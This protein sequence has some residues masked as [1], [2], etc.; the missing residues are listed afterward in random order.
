M[1]IPLII[2]RSLRQHALSTLV[3]A[4]SIALA[5]GLL[6]TVWMVRAQS[7]RA[8]LETS[9][10]F[11]GVLAA[12]GSEL[13][14]VLNAIFHM[15]SSPGNISVAD[16]ERVKK[17]PAVKAAIPVA[18]GDNHKGWRIVGTVPEL[19]TDVEYTSG[20][21][22]ALAHGK[23]FSPG[24]HSREALAGS[25]AAAQLGLSVGSV[26]RP[27]HGLA[28]APDREH[29]E[30]YR[31]TGV[32]APTNTPA[33]RVIW[34]PLEGVQHMAGHA[35]SSRS[36]LSAVLVQ[37]RAPSA[38]FALDQYYNKQGERLTFAYPTSA[39][40]ADFFNKIGWFD[41]VL[42]LVAFV[43]V[44]VAAG[45]VL[46][47]IYASMSTRQ[48]DIAI[49]RALGAR[50]GTVF[51]GMV[52]EAM[53][54]GALGAACGFA[55]YFVLMTGAAE[56]IREQTGVVISVAAWHA[57]LVWCPLGMIALGALGGIIPAV[58]AYRVPV[59]ETLSPLS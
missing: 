56:L 50:R 5:T 31:I 47:S 28:H 22:F 14:I 43:V 1:T 46:A 55:I 21:K 25:F 7:Q 33:D 40:I 27:S 17:H 30:E 49:L 16:Y 54:I 20:K 19:F 51:G 36:E 38:G 13:Q 34:I 3:T 37:L 57:V 11:D 29:D 48:R 52:L 59:A 45:S 18:T 58:K 6:M 10:S 42:A 53:V 15:E 12:R 32:L 41:R 9:T 35:E 26:F 24:A 23:V 44:L 2:Y 4:A 39:I 8:F